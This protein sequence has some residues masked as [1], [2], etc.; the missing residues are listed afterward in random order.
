MSQR[1]LPSTYLWR[2]HVQ[3]FISLDEVIHFQF[4]I[5]SHCW[6]IDVHWFTHWNSVLIIE[7]LTK[8]MMKLPP[9]SC[10]DWVKFLKSRREVSK[11]KTKNGTTTKTKNGLLLFCCCCCVCC[12][13][14]DDQWWMIQLASHKFNQT[15]SCSL[16]ELLERCFHSEAQERLL[17]T[18]RVWRSES[19]V[20][21][22]TLKNI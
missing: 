3:L 6:S 17:A 10:W 16:K 15:W 19:L 1:T 21:K 20:R 7:L 18:C 14:G 2:Y 8:W 12:C 11:S 5:F 13:C 9:L 22:Q 4:Q